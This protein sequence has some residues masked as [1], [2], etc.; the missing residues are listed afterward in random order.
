MPR[1]RA[2][3]KIKQIKIQIAIHTRRMCIE[4][5]CSHSNG[6]RFEPQIPTVQFHVK[7][8][9]EIEFCEHE[10]SKEKFLLSRTSF[11]TVFFISV[12][13][14]NTLNSLK[15]CGLK[16]IIRLVACLF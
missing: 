14:R 13:N 12:C 15:I 16:H 1:M 10:T 5:T 9:S 8:K 11:T 2:P 3:N 6:S 4:Q 7:H